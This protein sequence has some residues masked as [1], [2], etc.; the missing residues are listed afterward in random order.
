MNKKRITITQIEY[1]IAAAKY[2]NFT[3]AAR[4]LYVSQSSLS[5]QIAMIE[6]EVGVQLFIRTNRDVSLTLAGQ[7]L[8]KELS[9][10][11]E[12]ISIAI[13][14]SRQYNLME[15]GTIR[16]GCLEAMDTSTFLPAIIKKFKQTY[17]NVNL[18]L[19]RHSFK[20]LRERIINGTLDIIFTLSFESDDS[21]GIDSETLYHGNGYII[22]EASNPLANKDNLTIKD[23]KNESFVTLSRDE[24]P[25]GYDGIISL[26]KKHGFIP[27]IVKQ[28]PNTESLL[29]CV[30]SGLGVALLD[31]SA[32]INNNPNLIGFKIE[33]DFISV[34]MAWRKE[35]INETIP[36]FTNS[37]LNEVRMVKD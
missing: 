8:F 27:K 4:N 14:K 20:L 30:E 6:E 21:L 9:G 1:F 2:L 10:I 31:S 32:R 24:T 15:N 23:L 18:V 36:L 11:P 33:D 34:I 25:R 5:K 37:M 22:M 12:H 7:V 13:E 28:L 16:I 35:N 19:E 26:C 3:E 29:L 17:P